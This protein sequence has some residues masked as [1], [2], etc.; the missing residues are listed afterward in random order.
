[1]HELNQLLVNVSRVNVNRAP[2]RD[3][4]SRSIASLILVVENEG[5]ATLDK[6][7]F[8]GF[9]DGSGLWLSSG[10]ILLPRDGLGFGL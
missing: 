6:L 3:F 7:G 2:S 9:G 10:H 4:K 8:K 1:M 5:R